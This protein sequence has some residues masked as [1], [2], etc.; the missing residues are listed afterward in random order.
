MD[1]QDAIRGTFGVSSMVLKS[2]LEDIDDNELM[3]RPG[4]GCNHLA[5]QLGHLIASECNLLESVSPGSAVELPAGFAERHSKE[6][7]GDDNQANFSTKQEYLDLMDR[8]QQAS[9]AALKQ[10]SESSLDEPS[11]EHFRKTFPTVGHV[12]LLIAT[13]GL[14]HAGQFVPAR[15]ALGKPIVI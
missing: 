6:T 1:V 12:F 8:V 13:H 15:R 4:P 5:W 3:T 10:T 2:Y 9:L 14:M 11:P 7:T